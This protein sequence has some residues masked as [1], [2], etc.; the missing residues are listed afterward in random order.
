MDV[1]PYLMFSST[2]NNMQYE[3]D[4]DHISCEFAF[5]FKWCKKT[6]F[7]IADHFMY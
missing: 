1:F 3:R 7:L 6:V 4:A 5:F 2:N